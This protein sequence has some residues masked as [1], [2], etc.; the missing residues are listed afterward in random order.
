MRDHTQEY[1][2]HFVDKVFLTILGLIIGVASG[3]IWAGLY[4]VPK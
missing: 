4:L 3:I 1:W 2:E